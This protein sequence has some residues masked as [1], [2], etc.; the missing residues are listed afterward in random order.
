MRLKYKLGARCRHIA[1]HCIA[2]HCIALRCRHI[3]LCPLNRSD[4]SATDCK[5]LLQHTLHCGEHWELL[6]I[7]KHNPSMSMSAAR[8]KGVEWMHLQ[9]YTTW[10]IAKLHCEQFI[11]L[12][13]EN[14]WWFLQHATVREL[15]FILQ[16]CQCHSCCKF[17][18]RNIWSA[19]MMVADKGF[20]LSRHGH[21]RT[22][23]LPRQ[24]EGIELPARAVE[25]D[26]I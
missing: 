6:T 17:S 14:C 23:Q 24:R 10:C 7:Q 11:V 2:L 26:Q 22:T 15:K 25:K 5:I 9:N 13:I 4:D 20:G 3:A 21:W 16:I 19:A 18:W 8:N 12:C 1:L